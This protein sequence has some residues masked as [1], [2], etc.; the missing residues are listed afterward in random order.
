MSHRSTLMSLILSLAIATLT[1]ARAGAQ[2]PPERATPTE[3]SRMKAVTLSDL[4]GHAPFELTL[5]GAVQE[6]FPERRPCLYSE[7]LYGEHQDGA[8]A[9]WTMIGHTGKPL[10]AHTP[11]GTIELRPSEWRLHVTPGVW[12]T[13]TKA[14]SAAAPEF[15]RADLAASA[16]PLTVAA[17]ELTA[18]RTYFGKVDRL[19]YWLPP[20]NHGE[21]P[22]RRYAYVL[23]IS[24][25]PFVDGKPPQ[26]MTPYSGSITF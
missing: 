21:K 3:D 20:A 2:P 6:G 22:Q 16:I 19:S 11:A 25:A 1:M 9:S 26:P 15:I 23:V 24:D 13:Y 18:G 7:A 5:S 8:W 12:Q 10:T 4:Q 14:D 17:Y